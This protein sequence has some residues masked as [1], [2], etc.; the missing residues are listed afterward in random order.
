MNQKQRDDYLA[1]GHT[2]IGWLLVITDLDYRLSKIDPNYTIDQIKEK[3]GGLRY[4]FSQSPSITFR[5][6][7]LL[8]FPFI[9]RHVEIYHEGKG[10]AM[11]RLVIE[12]ERKCLVTCEL[13]GKGEALVRNQGGWNKTLCSSCA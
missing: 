7:F 9:C 8:R 1:L 6:P 12:A 3:F 13:C 11:R 2:D 4:Y 5:F 10:V